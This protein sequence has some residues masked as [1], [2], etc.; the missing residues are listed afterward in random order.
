MRSRHAGGWNRYENVFE[1]EGRGIEGQQQGE[2]TEG[3]L[4]RS[5]H[6]GG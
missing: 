2:A 1:W 6:A 3:V 5:K 4:M